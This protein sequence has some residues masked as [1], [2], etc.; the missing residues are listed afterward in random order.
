L[1]RLEARDELRR[2]LP[3]VLP[4]PDIGHLDEELLAGQDR[5]RRLDH[6]LRQLVL[7]LRE[8]REL[9]DRVRPLEQRRR[10]GLELDLDLLERERLARARLLGLEAEVELLALLGVLLLGARLAAPFAIQLGAL[11]ALLLLLLGLFLR[12]L[13]LELALA[14]PLLRF[15]LRPL[16]GALLFALAPLRF[17][18]LDELVQ[19]P[20]R[21]HLQ[22]LLHLDL[23]RVELLEDRLDLLH[24]VAE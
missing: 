1:E 7:L 3:Q 21:D 24:R 12:A 16:F 4:L 2:A 20:L 14:A 23:E 11:L 6:E 8:R 19:L 22:A 15:G 5:L 10:V 9:A 18:A 13:T 17:V